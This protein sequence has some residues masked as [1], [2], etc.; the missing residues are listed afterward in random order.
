MHSFGEKHL[1]TTIF[2]SKSYLNVI[3]GQ[4]LVRIEECG[5]PQD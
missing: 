2:T 3:F 4:I 1:Q 5:P